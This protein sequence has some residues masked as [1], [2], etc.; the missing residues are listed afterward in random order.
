MYES[1]AEVGLEAVSEAIGMKVEHKLR[2][3]GERR[4][5][6]FLGF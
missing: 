5:W 6:S 2:K 3:G 1:A 4:E